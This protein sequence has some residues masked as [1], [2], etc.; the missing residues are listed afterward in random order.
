[1]LDAESG[2]GAQEILKVISKARVFK[3]EPISGFSVNAQGTLVAVGSS[4]GE[5]KVI[6]AQKFTL[7]KPVKRAH[8]IFVTAMA[9]NP[10]GNVVLS[11]SADASAL[12]TKIKKQ[13]WTLRLLLWFTVLVVLI[14]CW[15]TVLSAIFPDPIARVLESR[16]DSWNAVADFFSEGIKPTSAAE[17]IA[18][19]PSSL[20]GLRDE[21]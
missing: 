15:V 10:K 9:W 19:D 18:P 12:A 3:S 13:S 8:M 14:L 17:S 7:I 2:A 21:L 11:G 6:D 1:M 16:P 20:S 4:E 5:V